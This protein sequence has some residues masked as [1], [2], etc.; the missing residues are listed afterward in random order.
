MSGTSD[1]SGRV[2]AMRALRHAASA[3]LLMLAAMAALPTAAQTFDESVAAYER[4]DH[5]T[6][7]RGFR[8]LAEQGDASAQFILGVMFRNGEGVAQD[9]AEAVRWYRRAAE[10]G[11][12]SAQSNLGVMFYKGYGVPQDYAEAVR[13]YRRAAEQGEAKAQNNLGLMFSKG[14]GVAQGL[15]RGHDMVSARRRAGRGQGSVQSRGHVL[16]RRWRPAG[17]C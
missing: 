14:D 4:G 13:W 8:N 17:L 11:D 10:Q 16:Q 1:N 9:Y 15:C 3:L 12:A 5:A 2:I 7:H 6:A